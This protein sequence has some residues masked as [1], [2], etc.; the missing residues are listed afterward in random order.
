MVKRFFLPVSRQLRFTSLHC[1]GGFEIVQVAHQKFVRDPQSGGLHFIMIWSSWMLWSSGYSLYFRSNSAF[2]TIL[3]SSLTLIWY[4]GC[5]AYSGTA[6]LLLLE[7]S[8]LMLTPNDHDEGI[9]GRVKE[10]REYEG[11]NLIKSESPRRGRPKF[12]VDYLSPE[13]WNWGAWEDRRI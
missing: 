9:V 11:V 12:K 6:L 8:G 10:E 13:K 2:S 1:W 7:T 4:F 5:V 3:K